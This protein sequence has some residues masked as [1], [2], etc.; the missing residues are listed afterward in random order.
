MK[1]CPSADNIFLLKGHT[2]S[3]FGKECLVF[4][5]E[6]V[7]PFQMYL[8]WSV[9]PLG[10]T[11]EQANLEPIRPDVGDAGPELSKYKILFLIQNCFKAVWCKVHAFQLS[12]KRRSTD[13]RASFF[14]QFSFVT[15]IMITWA[16]W[17]EVQCLELSPNRRITDRRDQ[18]VHK[19]KKKSPRSLFN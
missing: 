13:P 5:K 15:Q 2:F 3:I 10:P 4:G 8:S 7:A 9:C 11:L 6:Y 16:V 18:S 19:S 12:P 17:C 1:F 14:S